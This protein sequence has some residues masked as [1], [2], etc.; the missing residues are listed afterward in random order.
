MGNLIVLR[1]VGIKIVFAVPLADG[2]DLAAEEE[3]GL[4][5]GI[6][7]SLVH[8]RQRPRE[9]EDDGVGERVGFMPVAGGDTG[10][11]LGL[12]LD[13][14]VDFQTD[15]GFV[16]RRWRGRSEGGCHRGHGGDTAFHRASRR[17]PRVRIVERKFRRRP[18]WQRENFR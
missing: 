9:C 11:H 2:R 13:L 7:R 4:D 1:G 15:D 16:D 3:A 6:E 8:D 17:R 10:K 5:D 12:S 18:T 14:D